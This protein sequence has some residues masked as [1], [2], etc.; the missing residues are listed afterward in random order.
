MGT[1]LIKRFE[2]CLE[3]AS[4]FICFNW[5]GHDVFSKVDSTKT[6]KLLLEQFYA[7]IK[8]VAKVYDSK[9]RSIIDNNN[10]IDVMYYVTD[11]EKYCD[12]HRLFILVLSYTLFKE[13]RLYFSTP[14]RKYTYMVRVSKIS[15][16]VIEEM[17][18]RNKTDTYVEL[19]MCAI[20][21][22]L[23]YIFC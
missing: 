3:R 14:E 8:S 15:Q 9:I 10:V 13:K 11:N 20:T 23:G 19:A 6:K 16:Y 12:E 4:G 1:S 7:I 22:V 17:K 2:K 5:Y 18:H 21:C